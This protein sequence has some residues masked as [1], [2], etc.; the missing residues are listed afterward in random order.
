MTEKTLFLAWQDRRLTRSW[1]P[2]GR[3]DVL[4]TPRSYRFRYTKGAEVAQANA[5][6]EPLLDFPEW[7]QNYTSSELFPLFRNRVI[8]SDRRDFPEYLK[9]LD[10]PV[11]AEPAE[12]LEVGGGSRATDNFEVFPKLQRRRDGSFNCRFFVHGSRHVNTASIQRIDTLIPGEKL[13]VTLELTNPV[14]KLAIQIQTLDYHVIGWA[15]RYLVDDLSKAMADSPG[16]YQAHVVRVNP[17]PA[18]SKQRLLVELSCNWLGYE[19]MSQGPFEP[20]V[21]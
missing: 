2:I 16:T 10:L 9:M 20:L 4:N 7:N 5:G 19:P 17:S 14:T 1:F 6:F 15:P 18:P 8:S 3:L 11:T 13:Y 12:I 21:Q